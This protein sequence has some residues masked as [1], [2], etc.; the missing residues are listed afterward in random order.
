MTSSREDI[1]GYHLT[2]CCRTCRYRSER[3]YMIAFDTEFQ[4][5]YTKYKRDIED[6]CICDS[7][8]NN[9]PAGTENE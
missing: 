7:F 3:M 2:A 9:P 4:E 8:E 6:Y 5:I 1:P